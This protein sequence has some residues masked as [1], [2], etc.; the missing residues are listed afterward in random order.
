MPAEGLG[1][2]DIET[3]AALRA[4]GVV[5]PAMIDDLVRRVSTCGGASPYVAEVEQP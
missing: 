5:L 3:A 1:S 2:S 4:G